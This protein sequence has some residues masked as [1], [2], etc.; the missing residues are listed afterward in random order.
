MRIVQYSNFNLDWYDEKFILWPMPEEAAKDVC[1]A[2]NRH[3]P[4]NSEHRYRVVDN[5]YKPHI[6]MEP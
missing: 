2:I 4:D 1:D 3:L 6:G 5:D